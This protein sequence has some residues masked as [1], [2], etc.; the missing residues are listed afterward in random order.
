MLLLTGKSR[1]SYV[2]VL[3]RAARYRSCGR[4]S[5][6]CLPRCHALAL[7]VCLNVKRAAHAAP[8]G[9]AEL[10][11]GDVLLFRSTGWIGFLSRVFERGLVH[12]S[13]WDHVGLV[14]RRDGARD[15][16]GS[17]TQKFPARRA[18]CDGYCTCKAAAPS[19]AGEPALE[20]AESTGAGTHIYPL[21]E[22]L[23]QLVR[24]HSYVAIRKRVGHDSTQ[25]QLSNLQAFL[26]MVC[27]RAYE[28][29]PEE[30]VHALCI[31]CCSSGRREL[32]KRRLQKLRLRGA[33]NPAKKK[34]GGAALANTV[35]AITGKRNR[36]FW[37]VLT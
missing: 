24:H 37:S 30:M 8:T 25:V 34:D 9:L 20:L 22:R 17:D 12:G 4:V 1:T 14:V 7:S 36:Y 26:E 23:A 10:R 18:C 11:T 13:A 5:G 29:H 3:V 16:A 2:V 6:L 21:E 27:G 32:P 19:S 15:S 31:P 33:L 28:K 35:A